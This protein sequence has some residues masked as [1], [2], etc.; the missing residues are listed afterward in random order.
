VGAG[1]AWWMHLK[2]ARMPPAKSRSQRA[3]DGN[4]GIAMTR[5]HVIGVPL[6]VLRITLNAIPN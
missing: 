6:Q 1:N 4:D 5:G 3:S 2:D